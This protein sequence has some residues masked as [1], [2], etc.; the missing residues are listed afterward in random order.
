MTFITSS[1]TR[2][3]EFETTA[4][5]P[6]PVYRQAPC[7]S[8]FGN[9]RP[10]ERDD[11]I[12]H[13]MALPD[14]QC[15]SDLMPTWLLKVCARDLVPFL[16][17]LFNASL[18]IGV[19]PDTFKSAYVTPILKKSGL[20]EDDAKNY[21]PISNLSVLSKLL[22]RLVAGQ[23]VDYLSSHNLLPENQSAYRANH[24]TETAIAKVLS[25]ILMAIDHGDTAALALLDCSAAFDTVDHDILLRKLSESF[26]VGGNVLP[27][28][29]SYLRG[30]QQC[31]RFGGLQF[32]Y[33]SVAYGVPQGS[34]LGLL[35]FIIYTADLGSLVT[36]RRLH[37]HQYADDIQVY[38]WRPQT[39]SHVLRDQLSNSVEDIS[40]WMCSH[41]L[42]LNTSKTEFI[43]CC[44]SRR[45]Q[46]LPDSD[47]LA[48]ADQVPPISSARYLGVY[49]DGEM[50][51]R[52]HIS[53]V[54]GCLVFQCVAPDSFHTA[55]TVIVCAGD[56][57][58]QSRPLPPRL[59]QCRLC[60]IAF[61]RRATTADNPE[62]VGST[63]C[64]RTQV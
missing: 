1:S 31:V 13:I 8:A 17:R 46:H 20:A 60:G 34:V 49:V 29:A 56:A 59:L 19:F 62:L 41:R 14:K 40:S 33:E 10:V 15:A 55:I 18:L 58:H 4:G 26:G 11:V 64:W 43:W 2:S 50:S 5:A 25:D 47:F 48:G 22:E 63:S 3:P 32:K 51:L 54:H 57:S 24:S 21:R 44:P 30:R 28:F 36:A 27:W 45:R 6:D 7:D 9:F 52:S 16:C 39:E 12:K 35:L 61:T 42:Q 23:L 37:S 38:G 53:H